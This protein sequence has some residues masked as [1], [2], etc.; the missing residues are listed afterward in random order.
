[1]MRI[2]FSDRPLS[3]VLLQNF[4]IQDCSNFPADPLHCFHFPPHIPE[5]QYIKIVTRYRTCKN[6]QLHCT[7]PPSTCVSKGYMSHQYETIHDTRSSKRFMDGL[8]RVLLC[9]GNYA[10][11]CIGFLTQYLKEIIRRIQMSG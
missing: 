11:A 10:P 7:Y 5:V 8:I 9:P 4:H 2:C 3:P 6:D 1:M